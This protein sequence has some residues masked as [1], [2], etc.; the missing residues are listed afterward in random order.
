[1]F[2]KLAYAVIL[3]AAAADAEERNRFTS[4]NAGQALAHC[5]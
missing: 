1:M 5:R 2:L 4:I 3:K